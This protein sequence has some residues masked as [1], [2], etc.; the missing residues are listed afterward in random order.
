MDLET[1]GAK[2]SSKQ[3][4]KSLKSKNI[5]DKCLVLAQGKED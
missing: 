2:R 4:I 3:L 1:D 5:H